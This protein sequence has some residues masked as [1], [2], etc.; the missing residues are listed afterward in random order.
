MEPS[1]VLRFL[2]APGGR[3]LPVNSRRSFVRAYLAAGLGQVRHPVDFVDCAM[4]WSY[5]HETLSLR[6]PVAGGPVPASGFWT[7]SCRGLPW[8]V[9]RPFGSSRRCRPSPVTR[10]LM[11]ALTPPAAYGVPFRL[12]LSESGR[13]SRSVPRPIV[14]DLPAPK[15]L[16][17]PP[18]GFLTWPW[19]NRFRLQP[20][21]RPRPAHAPPRPNHQPTV[22]SVGEYGSVL[23]PQVLPRPP[24]GASGFPTPAW[25]GS[26]VRPAS[27]APEHPRILV[28]CRCKARHGRTTPPL[29]RMRLRTAL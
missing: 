21:E 7:F 8:P 20:L 27:E 2:R 28:S 18:R 5:R 29:N 17:A 3:R 19:L 11:A 6:L 14:R 23:R 22:A 9:H 26:R 12:L 13:R 24:R 1:Q 15:H 10:V 4:Q 16:H 25:R